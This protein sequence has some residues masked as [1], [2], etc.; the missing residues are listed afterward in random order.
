MHPPMAISACL[1]C[2][3]PAKGIVIV[4][5]AAFGYQLS[6]CAVAGSH[7]FIMKTQN[8]IRFNSSLDSSRR[9]RCGFLPAIIGN[10]PTRCL[11]QRNVKTPHQQKNKH[12]TYRTRMSLRTFCSHGVL[13]LIGESILFVFVSAKPV[14]MITPQTLAVLFN[15]KFNKK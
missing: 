11:R 6:R 9:F 12:C 14:Q 3:P 4:A 7:I 15:Y 10:N 2:T 1:Q 5:K 8:I 13:L